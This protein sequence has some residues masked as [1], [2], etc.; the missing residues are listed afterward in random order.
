MKTLKKSRLI[1][2]L[3]TSIA[4]LQSCASD[5]SPQ[6]VKKPSTSPTV[7]KSV[8]EY[9]PAPHPPVLHPPVLQ[10]PVPQPP[11]PQPPAPQ[12]PGVMPEVLNVPVVISQKPRSY[13]L[14]QS[15]LQSRT[16]K[17]ERNLVRSIFRKFPV[18][19]YILGDMARRSFCMEDAQTIRNELK[20][21]KN[22]PSISLD[23]TAWIFENA[24][25]TSYEDSDLD[26][27]I[28]NYRRSPRGR[29]DE[30]GLGGQD[31]ATALATRGVYKA[32]LQEF[33]ACMQLENSGISCTVKDEDDKVSLTM[34]WQNNSAPEDFKRLNYK[35]STSE[36]LKIIQDNEL[37]LVSDS[38]AKV[39]FLRKR[40]SL[41]STIDVTFANL[42][43]EAK[44]SCHVDVARNLVG[45]GKDADHKCG[46]F[47]INGANIEFATCMVYKYD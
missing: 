25:I 24:G 40:Q 20:F 32:E 13:I 17:C 8:P 35:I 38:E 44:V 47:R 9:T 23:R 43:G 16:Q 18:T 11:T 34:V 19:N 3:L 6:E 7:Q 15:I 33:K 27:L 29:C 1:I 30:P 37:S 42:E 21:L 46:I 14:S 45:E 41:S 10:P 5:E 12:T 22:N 4:N 36:N 39:T 31:T 28:F 26:D 2:A